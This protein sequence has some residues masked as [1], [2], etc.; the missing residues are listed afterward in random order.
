MKCFLHEGLTFWDH[1]A[2]LCIIDNTNLARLR[3]SGRRAILVPEMVAFA[4]QNGFQF[5]CHEIGHANRKAGEERSFRT[6][7]T[8]FL[9]GRTFESLEDLNRQAFEWATVRMEQ[10]VVP[11]TGLI[12]A[13]A[14]EEERPYLT[15]LTPHLPPPY[16]AHK[17]DI[18]QYGYMSFEANDYWV[19]GSDRGPVSFLKNPHLTAALI[20]RLTSSSHVI[21][22]KNCGSMRPRLDP[23]KEADDPP[24]AD[25]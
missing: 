13:R 7:E 8:N 10:R 3:G 11:K 19:P 24:D 1:A 20:D 15:K 25:S 14:F 18:N 9:P 2:P 4:E 21:N 6:V 22:M 12:P 23:E 16:L 17:R 5:V